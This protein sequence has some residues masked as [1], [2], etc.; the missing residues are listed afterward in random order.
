MTGS[1]GSPHQ[2][3][4][5]A[6]HRRMG[7][8]GVSFLI[9][10]QCRSLM[11]CA[12]EQ[13]S[14]SHRRLR[15]HRDISTP[16]VSDATETLS[17]S[18]SH[19]RGTTLLKRYPSR[20]GPSRGQARGKDFTRRESTSVFPSRNVSAHPLILDCIAPRPQDPVGVDC[21][22]RTSVSPLVP[23]SSSDVLRRRS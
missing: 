17:P 18:L 11:R 8:F 21:N 22:Q 20:R 7:A 4:A 16:S 10:P 13:D 5:S 23:F 19:F 12:I 1:F 9:V 2:R 6:L 14:E 3:G 15:P